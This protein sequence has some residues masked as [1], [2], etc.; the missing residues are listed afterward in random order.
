VL[1][2]A[3]AAAPTVPATARLALASATLPSPAV[4]P[5]QS[6][7]LMM[8]G[9]GIPFPAWGAST[10]WTTSGA[11]TDVVDGRKITTVY[12]VGRNGNRV[13]YAIAGGAPLSGAHGDTVTRYGVRFTLQ[14]SGP[15]RLITWVRSGHT[16]VIAG[17]SVSYSTLLAL[18]T[19][20]EQEVTS[21]QAGVTQHTVWL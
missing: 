20:D 14:R 6:Q 11:R 5:S 4:D 2:S 21:S 9:A 18:A 8:T 13:G 16:C 10:G 19:A 7:D 1:V 17:R 3:G 15:A 12:Y